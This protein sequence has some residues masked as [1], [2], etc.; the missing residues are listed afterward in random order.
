MVTA[1]RTVKR[2]RQRAPARPARAAADERLRRPYDATEKPV[3]DSFAEAWI[4]LEPTFQTKEFSKKSNKITIIFIAIA[5]VLVLA[6]VVS[7]II[8]FTGAKSP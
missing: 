7:L 2:A 8:A 5:V 4:G 1:K 3:G 6:I